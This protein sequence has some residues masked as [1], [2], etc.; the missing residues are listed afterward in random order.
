MRRR[1][2]QTSFALL[3]LA[4]FKV[5]SHL[6]VQLRLKTIAVDEHAHAAQKFTRRIHGFLLRRS[7]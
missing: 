5:E 2:R 1:G 3:L 7:G 4:E 6:F